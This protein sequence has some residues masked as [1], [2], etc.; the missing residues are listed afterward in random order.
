[1]DL[2]KSALNSLMEALDNSPTGE[3]MFNAIYPMTTENQSGYYRYVDVFSKVLC[4]GGSGDH[5]LNCIYHG[6]NE[7]SMFD[8]NSMTYYLFNLKVGLL[9]SDYSTFVDF[10][11]IDSLDW[12]AHSNEFFNR[13]IYL[14]FR[15]YLDEDTQTFWDKFYSECELRGKTPQ[16]SGL[17]RPIKYSRDILMTVNDYLSSEEAF[18]ALRERYARVKPKIIFYHTGIV[19]LFNYIPGKEKFN[20]I[21]F[22]NISDY[23]AQ[24]FNVSDDNR[25]LELFNN[26]INTKVMPSLA[27]VG[28]VFFAYIYKATTSP[29]WTVIDNID[30]LPVYFDNFKLQTFTAIGQKRFNNPYSVDCVLYKTNLG[31]KVSKPMKEIT[32]VHGKAQGKAIWVLFNNGFDTA[33]IADVMHLS[34]ISVCNYLGKLG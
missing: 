26:F 23:L 27:F 12:R 9:R 34:E 8:I 22:S 16:T 5:A 19:N 30:K 11:T 25:C 29:I 17:F 31:V 1:M 4:V 3:S 15:A 7:V 13:G 28:Q 21:L 20:L 10:F 14:D 2:L 32:E 24:A 6:A 18:L 33:Q